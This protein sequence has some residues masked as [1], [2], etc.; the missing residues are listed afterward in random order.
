MSFMVEPRQSGS[1]VITNAIQRICLCLNMNVRK[2]FCDNDD[3]GRVIFTE[4]LPH[5]IA[6]YFRRINRLV[7]QQ[8]HAALALG[9]EADSLLLAIMGMAVSPDTLLRLIRKAPEP[10]MSTPRGRWHLLNNLRDTLKRLMEG[11]RACLVAAADK[12]KVDNSGQDMPKEDKVDSLELLENPQKLTKR[13]EQ[14]L[15]RR[16]K[17]QER[18]EEAKKLHE[19]GVSK[20]EI[21]RRL[22]INWR[23]VSKYIRADECPIYAG[24]PSD[25]S[26]LTPFMDYIEKRWEEGCHNATQIWREIRKLGY[27]GA[28]RTFGRWATKKRKL[29]SGSNTGIKKITPWSASSAIPGT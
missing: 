29:A 27:D 19:L 25:S 20:A 22:S 15:L 8:Q 4:R 1:T 24:R 3:C 26:N 16:K 18:F 2:F 6:T 9:G 21:A 12:P 17:R 14:S 10:E 5:V 28:R 13:E 11:K 7:S 23:T